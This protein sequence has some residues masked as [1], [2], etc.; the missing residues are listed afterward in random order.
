VFTR[1]GRR[2]SHL[3]KR[4]ERALNEILTAKEV[5]VELRCSKAQVYKLINGEVPGVQK[6]PAIPLGKKKKVVMRSSLEAWKRTVETA[7]ISDRIDNDSEVN[8]VD[9]V[10]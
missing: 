1:G 3:S 6:L 9:A 10:A 4:V 8:A 7:R 5:A 2:L